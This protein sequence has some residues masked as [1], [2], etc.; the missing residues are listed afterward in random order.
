[1]RN[2][3]VVLLCVCVLLAGCS[4]GGTSPSLQADNAPPGVSTETQ[5]LTNA[6]ELL[7]AHTETLSDSGFVVELGSDATVARNGET[8]RVTR[9]QVIR[10][11]ADVTE[12]NYTVRNPRSRFDAWG[13]ETTQAVRAQANNRTRYQLGQAQSAVALSGTQF[14]AQYL[15]AGNWSVSDVRTE[16]GTQLV[17]LRSTAVPNASTAVPQGASDVRNYEA[18]VVVDTEGRIHSFDVTADYTIE[19]EDASFSRTLDLRSTSGVAVDRPDWVAE[20]VAS[21]GS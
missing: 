7:V 3:Q 10:A 8:R 2:A 19:G 21:S 14:L 20:A 15:T 6:T 18:V 11:E 13:N 17:T 4:L 16:D 5:E 12:Y 9:Q 1:M